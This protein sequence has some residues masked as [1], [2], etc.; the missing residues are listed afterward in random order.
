MYTEIAAT[1]TH[2]RIKK[3]KRL[4]DNQREM[5]KFKQIIDDT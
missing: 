5:E 3:F 1:G 4:V 2:T